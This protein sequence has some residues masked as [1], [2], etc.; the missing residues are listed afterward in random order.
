MNKDRLPVK[1]SWVDGQ[2]AG[3]ILA[4]PTVPATAQNCLAFIDA[5]SNGRVNLPDCGE[6]RCD[7][8]HWFPT[9]L[10]PAQFGAGLI[11]QYPEFCPVFAGEEMLAVLLRKSEVFL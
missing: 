5:M 11:S 7:I 9:S 4:P 10:L 1:F 6:I 8:A 2:L 3:R